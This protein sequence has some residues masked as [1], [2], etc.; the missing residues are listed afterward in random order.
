VHDFR[1]PMSAVHLD[2]QM[3]EREAKRPEGAR[4]ERLTD[5]AGRINRTVERMDKVFQE[6][7]YLARPAEEAREPV[8]LA[9]MR[10]GMHRNHDPALRT[11]GRDTHHCVADIAAARAGLAIRA[12]PRTAERARERHPVLAARREGRG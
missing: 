12:P 11:C 5:L 10:A 9:G 4:P 3:L 6:F 1:N 2:A 7:L 8:D